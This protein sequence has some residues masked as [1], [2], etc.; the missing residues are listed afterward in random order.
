MMNKVKPLTAPD[1]NRALVTFLRPSYFGGAIQFGVWDS[2][3][4]VGI[5]S[6]GAYVQYY[7]EPGEHIFLARA[8]NWSYVHADLEGGKRYY[9]LCKVFP[10]VWKARVAFDPIRKE[11]PNTDEEIAAW[12]KELEPQAVIPGKVSDY[13]KPR[14]EQVREAVADFRAGNVKS[15]VLKTED[16]R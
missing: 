2:D 15:E 1:E 13:T 4:F 12:L 7:A 5:A 16:Y 6:A 9:I 8:E 3:R 11:D 10:G 14:V